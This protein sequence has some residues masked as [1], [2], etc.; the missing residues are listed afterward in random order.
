MDTHSKRHAEQTR[1]IRHAAEMRL[2]DALAQALAAS[3]EIAAL[4]SDDDRDMLCMM[5]YNAGTVDYLDAKS[6][7]AFLVHRAALRQLYV[8]H[9]ERGKKRDDAVVA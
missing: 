4:Y 7:M 6:I 9:D 8:N 5:K 2:H 1:Q 3:R